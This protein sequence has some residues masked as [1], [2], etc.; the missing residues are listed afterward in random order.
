MHLLLTSLGFVS[1]VLI[2]IGFGWAYLQYKAA[3]WNITGSQ[4]ALEVDLY[5]SKLYCFIKI[6]FNRLNLEQV[7][8]KNE[9]V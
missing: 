6:K 9:K 5:Q 3:G 7:G 8:F 2:P 4:C 1:L